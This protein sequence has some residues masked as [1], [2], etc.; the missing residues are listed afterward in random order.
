MFCPKCGSILT[1]KR[2]GSKK[3]L[4][5]S[6]GYK[7]GNSDMTLQE[8]IP[9]KKYEKDVDIVTKGELETLP[10]IKQVCPKCGHSEAYY[11]VV[12]TRAADEA[13]TRFFRCVK[14]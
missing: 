12:Q 5:C 4:A 3:L 7:T 13:A 1:P 10:K 11:W 14:C 9:K 8:N 6:C 2:E